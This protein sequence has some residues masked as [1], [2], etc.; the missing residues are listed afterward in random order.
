MTRKHQKL[1]MTLMLL[2]AMVLMF[3]TAPAMADSIVL[4][5]PH[6]G[7]FPSEPV[8]QD[9]DTQKI[10]QIHNQQTRAVAV[11]SCIRCGN[12]IPEP[13]EQCDT[14]GQTATCD[15]DCTH[16]SCGDGVVNTP[17]GEQ[18][19]DGNV[20]NGDGCSSTCQTEV[21]LVCGNGVLQASEECDDGNTVAT[22]FCTNTCKNA[23]C[24]DGIVCSTC[25]EQC[26]A[27]GQPS[28]TCTSTCTVSS[29]GDGIV[30]TAAGEECD[31]P[32]QGSCDATCKIAQTCPS[33]VPNGL[34]SQG[35]NG[36][37]SLQ[38]FS[39]FADCDQNITNGCEVPIN[40]DV[41][42]C[43]MCGR[44]CAFPNASP[45]CSN[46]QCGVAACSPGWCDRDGNPLN[47]CETQ[48]CM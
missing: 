30:N 43:G 42:N 45:S 17:A 10:D 13:G 35:P 3:G 32:N 8:I 2:L 29:C 4:C 9:T 48:Q 1:S 25:G 40:N 47:G 33:S 22:D 34:V 16:V 14:G 38:C 19:D 36:S 31:P 12:G 28:P 44:I 41:N 37:C 39:G 26:D 24:G 15:V 21:P 20:L 18:C 5:P 46:G 11:R 23:R 6:T 27:G 7:D